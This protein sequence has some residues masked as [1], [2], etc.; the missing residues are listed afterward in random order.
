M[1]CGLSFSYVEESGQALADTGAAE[2]A[3]SRTHRSRNACALAT[4]LAR[5]YAVARQHV[6]AG[7]DFIWS[8][9]DDIE[10]PVDAL[11][12]LVKG[13]GTLHRQPEPLPDAL[14]RDLR[15]NGFSGMARRHSRSRPSRD[16]Y[17]PIDATRV[18]TAC[19]S[20]VRSSMVLLSARHAIGRSRIALT[21]GRRRTIS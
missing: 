16:S 21:I 4:H 18:S 15:I 20:G 3:G 1:D 5:L 19:S 2:L 17:V 14:A 8:V 9:E 11:H 12:H 10:P 7:A 6:P 13:L